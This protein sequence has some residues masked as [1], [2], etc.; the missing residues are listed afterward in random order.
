MIANGHILLGLRRLKAY[1]HVSWAGTQGF[2]GLA[3]LTQNVSLANSYCTSHRILHSHI[4]N[5]TIDSHSYNGWE[6]G[7]GWHHI[8]ILIDSYIIVPAKKKH[9]DIVVATVNAISWFS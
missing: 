3:G 8:V 2:A 5:T 1:L 7:Y 4:G 6:W 9:V